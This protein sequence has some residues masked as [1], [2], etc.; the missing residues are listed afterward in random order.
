MCLICRNT[1]FSYLPTSFHS[2]CGRD[3]DGTFNM[4]LY[5]IYYDLVS[6]IKTAVKTKTISVVITEVRL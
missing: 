2:T 5:I 3:G 6:D 1:F 4:Y